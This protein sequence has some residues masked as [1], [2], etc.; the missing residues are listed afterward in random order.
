[1]FVACVCNATNL[2]IFMLTVLLE[3]C[4]KALGKIPVRFLIRY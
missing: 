3:Q 1:M 4:W 2:P